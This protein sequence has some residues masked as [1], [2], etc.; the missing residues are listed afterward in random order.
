MGAV[1]RIVMGSLLLCD[2]GFD[3][4][5]FAELAQGGD[6]VGD[7]FPEPAINQTVICMRDYISHTANIRPIN[8]WLC[9][10]LELR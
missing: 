7:D 3:D 4:G 2:I 9:L 6:V 8:S 5:L 10:L 1:S